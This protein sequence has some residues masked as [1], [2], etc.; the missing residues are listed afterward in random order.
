ME[1]TIR[2]RIVIDG[3]EEFIHATFEGGVKKLGNKVALYY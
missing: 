2:N 1:I 3:Q